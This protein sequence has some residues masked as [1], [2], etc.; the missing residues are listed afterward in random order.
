MGEGVVMHSQSTVQS[1]LGELIVDIEQSHH[2]FTRSQLE[3]IE[4][5]LATVD[6]IPEGLEQCIHAL[7]NDLIPHLMKEERILFPFITALE[8]SPERP[9]A[10][11]FGSIANPVRMMRVEHD[12]VQSLLAE[13][14]QITMHY[15][16]AGIGL[17]ELYAA[18]M[19]LDKDLVEH[20]YWEDEVL[21]PRALQLEKQ[22]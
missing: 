22:L 1:S 6:D 8:I 10:S 17:A 16:F 4:Q 15:Q 2:V 19:A 13:I 18:L 12:A 20:I 5:M 7:K 3:R 21:F 11:C 9:P 14:R